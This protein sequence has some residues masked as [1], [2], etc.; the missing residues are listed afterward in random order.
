MPPKPPDLIDRDREWATLVRSMEEPGPGLMLVLG[1][2]R[3]GKSYLLTRFVEAVGGVYVQATKK[4]EREQLRDVS[5][6]LGERF[7]DAALR[8]VALPD[9]DD[10]LAYVVER[11][12]GEPFAFV[13]DEFPYPPMRLRPSHRFSR[14]GGITSSRTHR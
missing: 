11:A 4:T 1:R 3:A 13:L 14:R 10:V 6:A 8:R 5:R 2:R 12:A 7:N 9:W